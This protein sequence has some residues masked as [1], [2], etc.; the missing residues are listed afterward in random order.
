MAIVGVTECLAGNNNNMRTFML[1]NA[2]AEGV[3]QTHR[4]KKK[5]KEKKEEE[6]EEKGLEMKDKFLP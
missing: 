6:E 3:L 2:G 4:K 5:K 1:I